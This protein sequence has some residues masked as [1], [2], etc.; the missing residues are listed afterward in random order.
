MAGLAYANLFV[1]AQEMYELLKLITPPENENA[2]WCPECKR[3]V[4]GYEVTY[5]EYHE[6]CGAYLGDAN[7]EE[8]IKKARKVLAKAEGREVKP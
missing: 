6:V 3:E 4:S 7:S 5:Q 2:W 1:A 8:W